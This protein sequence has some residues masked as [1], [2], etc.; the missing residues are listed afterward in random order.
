MR[1]CYIP[2]NEAKCLLSEGDV[3]LFRNTKSWWST[4]IRASGDSTYSHCALVS[5]T[6]DNICKVGEGD[7]QEENSPIIEATEFKEWLG[8]RSVNLE[9]Y[10]DCY[11]GEI[12]VF[13]PNKFHQ[14]QNFDCN[15][16]L[17][18][19]ETIY[20]NG[21]K[22]T[23][24]M[25]RMTGLPYGWS[26]IWNLALRSFVTWRYL[27]SNEKDYSDELKDIIYP[28]CS[29]TIA[30]CFS[31]HYVDLLHEKADEYIVPGSLANSPILSYAFTLTK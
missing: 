28:V 12:D 24:E 29:N 26:R 23:N 20:L 17:I 10:I 5:F 14:K 25:R 2:F 19:T 30:Y 8:G 6:Y 4:F 22:I 1:Y 16:R 13:V 18:K 3:L 21:R 15:L 27:F 31:K 7:K 9:R 11:G